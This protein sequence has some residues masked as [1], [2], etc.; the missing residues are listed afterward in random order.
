[1]VDGDSVGD[2]TG[3]RGVVVS[4][5]AMQGATR[6]AGPLPTSYLSVN[7]DDFPTVLARMRAAKAG[8]EQRQQELLAARYDLGDRPSRCHDEPGQGDPGRCPREATGGREWT[9]WPR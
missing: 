1:M 2:G 7:E 6:A 8:V 5:Y 9:P 3:D 4:A